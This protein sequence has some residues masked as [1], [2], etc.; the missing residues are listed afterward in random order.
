MLKNGEQ[1]QTVST[2]SDSSRSELLQILGGELEETY[3]ILKGTK[4]RG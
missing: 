4:P 3:S 1:V 2:G